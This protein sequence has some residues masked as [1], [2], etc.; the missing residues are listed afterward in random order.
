MLTTTKMIKTTLQNAE[1]RRQ[2]VALWW[3]CPAIAKS[4]FYI[5]SVIDMTRTMT[6]ALPLHMLWYCLVFRYFKRV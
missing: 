4:I 6:A 3:Q 1:S 5:Q 2:W